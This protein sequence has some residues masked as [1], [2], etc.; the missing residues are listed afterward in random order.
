MLALF[1]LAETD[2]DDFH[3]V[4]L[5]LKTNV[6]F[7]NAPDFVVVEP[8]RSLQLVHLIHYLSIQLPVVNL[9]R[10]VNQLPVGDVHADVA[11][12]AR[13]VRQGMQIVGRCHERRITR[14]VFLRS[15]I[16]GATVDL[17]LRQRLLQVRVLTGTDGLKFVQIHQQVVRQGHLL[18]EFVRQVQMVQI[19]LAQV[20]RQQ[21]FHESRLATTLRTNQRRHTLI[22][23]QRVHLQPMGHSRTEPDTQIRQHFGA[24]TRQATEYTCHMVLS[25]PLGK[26][27][28]K[29]P[30]GVECRDI[31]GIDVRLDVRLRILPLT[32]VLAPG[33]QDDAVQRLLRQRTPLRILP[34]RRLD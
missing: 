13:C 23:M 28:Q 32:D 22:A 15:A 9:T 25:V 29:L 17:A 7:L 2:L 33:S 1:R 31:L 8:I 27:G 3:N 20:F 34:F 30:D 4:L 12:T 6:Q 21:S 16:D 11:T 26:V 19:V 14:T 10:V 5:L 18:I 24:D